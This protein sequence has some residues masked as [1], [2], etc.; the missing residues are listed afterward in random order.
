[1][2]LSVEVGRV[3][4]VSPPPQQRRLR[5]C[6]QAC[7]GTWRRTLLRRA[8]RRTAERDRTPRPRALRTG[9]GAQLSD[10]RS[11]ATRSRVE[12]EPVRLVARSH[13]VPP[14]F[15]RWHGSFEFTTPMPHPAVGGHDDRGRGHPCAALGDVGQVVLHNSAGLN[16][17][18][19]PSWTLRSHRRGRLLRSTRSGEP[20][21]EQAA[22]WDVSPV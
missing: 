12:P 11:P 20:V 9:R 22:S 19:T 17:D 4:L 16:L 7:L 1:M 21:A 13:P 14:P 10:R 3:G 6:R 5:R 2:G 18:G 8:G 15:G